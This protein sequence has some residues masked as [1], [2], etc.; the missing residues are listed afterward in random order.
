MDHADF[1]HYDN[2]AS[3]CST[4]MKRIDTILIDL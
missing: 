3:D 2:L 4:T 1:E